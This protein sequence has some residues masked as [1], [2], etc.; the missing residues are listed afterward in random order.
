VEFDHADIFSDLDA[1]KTSF[2][3]LV[4]IVPQN[5]GDRPSMAMTRIASK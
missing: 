4:N 3:R 1:I 5:G 2:R